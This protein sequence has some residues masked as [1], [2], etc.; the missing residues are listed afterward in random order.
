[1]SLWAKVAMQCVCVTDFWETRG[2]EG[3]AKGETV[4]ISEV[5]LNPAGLV[6]LRFSEH[7]GWLDP[8]MVGV[9]HGYNVRG[10][11]PLVSLEDDAE[12]FRHHLHHERQP[13]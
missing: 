13:A 5:Y 2:I 10:F 1:M 12:L 11:Q 7:P 4:T 3:P 8:N 9:R 6:T